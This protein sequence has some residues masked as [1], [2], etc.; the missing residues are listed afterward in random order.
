M[1]IFSIAIQ[2]RIDDSK[3][4]REGDAAGGDGQWFEIFPVLVELR[5]EIAEKAAHN[6]GDSDI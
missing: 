1:K 6:R 4:E 5:D 2:T 3:G